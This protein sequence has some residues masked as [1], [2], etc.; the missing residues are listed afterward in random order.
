MR[1][2]FSLFLFMYNLSV[3]A[4]DNIRNAGNPY[5]VTNLL[6]LDVTHISRSDNWTGGEKNLLAFNVNFNSNVSYKKNLHYY[7][8]TK[9]EIG[10]T[11]SEIFQKTSDRILIEFL[12]EKSINKNYD[13]YSSSSFK[14]Q[15]LEG[16]S[17]EQNEKNRIS[18]FLNPGY[19]ETEIGI[20]T[21]HKYQLRVAPINLKNT[22]VRDTTLYHHI[23]ENYGVTIGK[24]HLLEMGSSLSFLYKEKLL[25]QCNVEFSYHGFFAYIPQ[26]KNIDHNLDLIIS[27][28]I[29][30]YFNTNFKLRM[31]HDK[32]IT[33]KV[34]WI[35]SLSLSCIIS[36]N[37]K[38][39]S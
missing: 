27:S 10:F 29:G 12:I 19:I 30:K 5:C 15:F 23:P 20:K 21:K 24:K 6:G 35:N 26:I 25:K 8:I 18:A 7:L 31:I 3:F 33:K 11:K 22:I 9:L 2:I 39:K 13:C 37:S 36:L 32:D 14:S 4:Q 28:P 16:Y 17:Y 1:L 38:N 34:Q